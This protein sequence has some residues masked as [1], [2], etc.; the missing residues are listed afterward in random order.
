MEGSIHT[1]MTL[2][3]MVSISEDGNGNIDG[4][5]LPNCNLPARPDN[6][7]PAIAEAAKQIDEFMTGKRKNFDIPCVLAGTEFQEDVWRGISNIPYG[8]TLS[9]QALAE[10]IGHPKAYRAVGTACGANPIPLIIPCHRVVGSNGGLG[11]F[12]GGLAM[13]KKLMEIEGICH[14]GCKK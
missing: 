4:V 12:L 8:E 6:E 7:T 11:G 10:K 1:Y 14:N 3:G 9:Y 5:Y 13:K 2:I